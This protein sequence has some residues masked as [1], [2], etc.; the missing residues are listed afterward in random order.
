MAA[1]QELHVHELYLALESQEELCLMQRQDKDDCL[2][3]KCTN[4]QAF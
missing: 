3:T 4:K 2:V 1:V